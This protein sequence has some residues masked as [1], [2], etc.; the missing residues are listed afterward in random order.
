MGA[1]QAEAAAPTLAGGMQWRRRRGARLA[2]AGRPLRLAQRPQGPARSAHR[3][4]G[5]LGRRRARPDQ[6]RSVARSVQPGQRAALRGGLHR[7]LSRRPARPQPAD[8]RLGQGRARPPQRRRRSRHPLSALPHLGGPAL[9]GPGD[10]S[11]GPPLPGLLSRLAARPRTG[12]PASA[13]PTRLRTWLSMWSLETSKCQGGAAAGQ[14]RPAGAGRAEH[15]RH[16]R[17]SQRRARHP[18]G[19]RIEGQEPGAVPGA[20]YFEDSEAN[21][22]AMVDLVSAW[23]AARS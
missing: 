15:R 12:C 11:V 9:H 23:I 14:D 17:V 6:D 3:L 10:R 5:R 2:A 13:G 20:H 18:R 7:P 4:D 22:T 19:A 1:Y 21:R 16:G 8:H